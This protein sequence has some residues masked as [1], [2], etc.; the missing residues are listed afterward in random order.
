MRTQLSILAI[1]VG[2]LAAHPAPAD[3]FTVNTTVDRSDADAADGVCDVD[4]TT[5]GAQC[6]LRAAIQQANAI[7]GPSTIELPAGIYKLTMR[8]A[9]EDGA[10]TG[11][12]DINGRLTIE[13]AG[14]KT[15]IIDAKR[16]KDRIFDILPAGNVTLTDVTLLR[17]RV[18]RGKAG[19]C[20]RNTGH[21]TLRRAVLTRCKSAGDGGALD[22]A[23]T[24]TVTD[25][26]FIQNKSRH[27][28][29]ALTTIAGNVTVRRCTFAA[30]RAGG[31]GGALDSSAGTVDVTN[32]TFTANRARLEGGAIVNEDNGV[33]TL[34]NCTIAGNEAKAGGGISAQPGAGPSVSPT[35]LRNCILADNK[36]AN[37]EGAVISDG[38]NLDS[39]TSCAFGAGSLSGTDPKL[40]PLQDNG[41]LTPTLALAADS[42][43]IDAG[44]DAECP[45]TDQRELPRRDIP[46]RGTAT[47]DIGAYEFQP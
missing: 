47:C 27:D 23:G 10:T 19:G 16:A 42:P 3:T 35:R 9:N 37:C 28:G 46:G 5:P 34:T 1:A 26:L 15:T 30:N 40:G 8:G 21:L 33:M 14:A 6:T 24:A 11:D 25:V 13:G 45:A 31:E 7:A 2:V 44:T 38:G 36:K 29:G 12:L 32:S 22:S 43:A 18:G 17:G 39:G 4:P 41:G 20:V